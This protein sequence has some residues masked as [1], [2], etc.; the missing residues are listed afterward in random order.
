[1]K[2]QVQNLFSLLAIITASLVLVA[3]ATYGQHA[4]QSVTIQTGR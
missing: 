3:C 4:G 2:L 1:M